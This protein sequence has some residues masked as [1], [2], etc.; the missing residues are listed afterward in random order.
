M[1][2]SAVEGYN[3]TSKSYLLTIK[4][5]GTQTLV[6]TPDALTVTLGEEFTEPALTGNKTAVTYSIDPE[7]VATIDAATG[8]LTLVAA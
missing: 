7:G 2:A 6:F 3:E 8:E 5:A 4:D 1:T